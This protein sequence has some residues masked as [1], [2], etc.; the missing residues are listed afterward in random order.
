[1]IIKV[2][3]IMLSN[4]LLHYKPILSTTSRVSSESGCLTPT[5]SLVPGSQIHA[6]FFQLLASP[7]NIYFLYQKLW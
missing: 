7:E 1:M 4:S 3:R 6:W 5:L 2:E